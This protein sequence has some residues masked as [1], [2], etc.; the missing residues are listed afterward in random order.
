MAH[1]IPLLLPSELSLPSPLEVE[2][3]YNNRPLYEIAKK[4][5]YEE[6]ESQSS[7]KEVVHL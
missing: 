5:G 7:G 6:A 4:L 2:G 3:H 1:A